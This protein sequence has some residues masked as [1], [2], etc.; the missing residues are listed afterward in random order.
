[1]RHGTPVSAQYKVGDVVRLREN[2]PKDII[3]H[4]VVT[5]R[6]SCCDAIRVRWVTSA[7]NPAF[8]STHVDEKKLRH[9]R[10]RKK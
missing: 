6:C 9:F 2:H 7:E 8:F 10:R 3:D 1:M 4:G 5:G